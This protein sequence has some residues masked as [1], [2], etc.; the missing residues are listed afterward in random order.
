MPM[1]MSI[2]NQY[3]HSITQFFIIGF[4]ENMKL[5]LPCSICI[6]ILVVPQWLCVCVC[7]I[8]CVQTSQSTAILL[9]PNFNVSAS[10]PL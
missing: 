10:Q 3:I 1:P 6:K 4:H 9:Y 5:K 7:V 8:Y 2:I